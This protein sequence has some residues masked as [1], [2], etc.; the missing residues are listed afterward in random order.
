MAGREFPLFIQGS[1]SLA[2]NPGLSRNKIKEQCFLQNVLDQMSPYQIPMPVSFKPEGPLDL[3]TIFQP[4]S[5]ELL[6]IKNT[7]VQVYLS[8]ALSVPFLVRI[9]MR[10]M[11][12]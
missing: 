3:T 11:I 6:Q 5:V 8:I 7:E 4:I 9:C 1:G 2:K 10:L 12:L